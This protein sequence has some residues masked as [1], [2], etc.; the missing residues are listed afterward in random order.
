MTDDDNLPLAL[1]DAVISR[2]AR[3]I[4]RDIYPPTE[5]RQKYKLDEQQFDRILTSAFFQIRLK[6]ELDLWNAS[7]PK[8]IATRIGVKSATMVEECLL[9]VYA[10]IHDKTQPM[11]PKIAALQWASRLAGVGENP[12]VR[13]AEVGP[14]DRIRFNIVINNQ[15]VSFDQSAEGPPIIEGAVNLNSPEGKIS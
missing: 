13:G 5:I 6:E 11:A 10:L 3:E 12:S 7:D 14:G 4:A 8:S 9:E 2:V 15:R 1:D